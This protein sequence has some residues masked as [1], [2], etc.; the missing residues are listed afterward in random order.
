MWAVP[1][2]ETRQIRGLSS[3][4]YRLPVLS[5]A[6]SFHIESIQSPAR[7]VD[8]GNLREDLRRT[9]VLAQP[10][11]QDPAV[12]VGHEELVLRAG[13]AVE[14]EAEQA[15]VGVVGGVDHG[16]VEERPVLVIRE[17]PLVVAVLVAAVRGIREEVA[18][19]RRDVDPAVADRDPERVARRRRARED[20]DRVAAPASAARRSPPRGA[21][22]P[23]RSS[24]TLVRMVRWL[25]IASPPSLRER[26]ACPSRS[27]HPDDED[28]GQNRQ[29][30]RGPRARLRP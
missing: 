24:M 26:P 8:A 9:G 27:R 14:G 11:R 5:N 18:G 10:D 15:H 29:G 12:H 3:G 4:T 23:R 17:D 16:R 1:S 30:R 6:R 22:P 2:G 7:P 25:P 20:R 28:R 19:A 13:I 21:P